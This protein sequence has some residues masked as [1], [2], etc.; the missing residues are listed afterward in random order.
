M[1][2][3][4]NKKISTPTCNST[5]DTSSEKDDEQSATYG[6]ALE[7]GRAATVTACIALV[8]V[9]CAPT[10]ATF[11]FRPVIATRTIAVAV[12]ASVRAVDDTNPL[13]CAS[14]WLRTLAR[15]SS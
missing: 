3:I 15:S 2:I 11:T 7:C 12:V 10:F 5:S 4:N 13:V 1:W 14:L 9:L 8:E 6:Y